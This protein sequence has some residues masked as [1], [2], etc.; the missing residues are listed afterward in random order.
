MQSKQGVQ[1]WADRPRMILLAFAVY[2]LAVLMT[3]GGQFRSSSSMRGSM[4]W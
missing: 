4:L 3:F 2:N 1:L